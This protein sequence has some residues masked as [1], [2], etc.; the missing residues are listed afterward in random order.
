VAV[1][2]NGVVTG[3]AEG[4]GRIVAIHADVGAVAHLT[5]VP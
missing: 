1:D 4:E 5:V 2:Q 3:L